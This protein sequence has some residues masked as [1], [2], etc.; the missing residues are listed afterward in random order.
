VST[1]PL[2]DEE[3]AYLYEVC[4]KHSER[5]YNLVRRLARYGLSED[6]SYP[7]EL[8]QA[9]SVK[10]CNF[11]T[12]IFKTPGNYPKAAADKEDGNG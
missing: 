11:Q 1:F 2:T 3:Q 12:A 10:H 5:A 7:D 6:P 9:P 4:Q 8:L